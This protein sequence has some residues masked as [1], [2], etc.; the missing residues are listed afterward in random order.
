MNPSARSLLAYLGLNGP[1]H[2][3]ELAEATRL[4]KAAVSTLARNLIEAGLIQEV[5]TARAP[6][7]QGRPSAL[8]DLE[9]GYGFLAGVR[10]DDDPLVSVL[11]DLKGGLLGQEERALPARPQ[12]E[13]VA[14]GIEDS[15]RALIT[16]AG[17]A[18]RR[19][20]GVG[21]AV[22]GIVDAAAGVVRHSAILGWDDVPLSERVRVR[23]GAPALVENDANAVAAFEHLY[24]SARGTDDFALVT[25]GRG[26][27]AAQFVAGRLQR[28]H[29]GSAGELAHCTIDP[30]GRLCACGKHGC[31]DTI[32]AR[33]AIFRAARERGLEAASL[34][35]L[36]ALAQRGDPHALAVLR[37]AAA[38]LGLA[39]SH[40]IHLTDP[41]L[42]LIAGSE[43]QP[44]TVFATAAR[45][46][47]ERNL[48]PRR[49]PTLSLAFRSLEP[50][51]WAQGAAALATHSLLTGRLLLPA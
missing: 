23:L 8:L 50:I 35:A 20:L 39:V 1:T 12:P 29:D 40:L 5:A 36:E 16:R 9:P 11:T 2:R 14:A 19:L 25:V 31:L 33:G 38:A 6:S 3:S 49:L 15:V 21:I 43:I 10:L 28:G 44:N 17:R 51:S 30:G 32:A 47:V 26:V 41:G 7:G 45:Q 24:G 18:P 13:E 4:S 37:G 42:V 48:L 46:E 22:S 34:S 27:G